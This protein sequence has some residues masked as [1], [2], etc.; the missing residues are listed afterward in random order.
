MA[1]EVSF[2]PEALTDLF[3]LYDYIEADSGAERAR[4]ALARARSAISKSQAVWRF[5]Q[6]R[7]V[8]SKWCPSRMAVSAAMARLPLTISVTRSGRYSHIPCQGARG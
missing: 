3:E 7:D 6:K 4:K 8:V 2:S 5:I 1:R